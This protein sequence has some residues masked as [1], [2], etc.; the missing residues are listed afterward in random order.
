MRNY[1]YILNEG[2]N[3]YFNK[4]EESQITEIEKIEK[5]PVF[6][7]PNGEYYYVNV[8][9]ENN[10]IYA[11][12]ATNNG[13]IKEFEIDYDVDDTLDGNLSRLYDTIIE[14]RP[15][16]L[17][18]EPIEESL[19][20]LNDYPGAKKIDT[21]KGIAVDT[22][23]VQS[24]EAEEKYGYYQGDIIMDDEPLEVGKSY[25]IDVYEIPEEFWDKPGTGYGIDEDNPYYMVINHKIEEPLEESKNIFKAKPYGGDKNNF[26]YFYVEPDNSIENII[27]FAK[28]NFDSC[29]DK[30][31]EEIEAKHMFWGTDGIGFEEFYNG[32]T[33]VLFDDINKLP[34][35]IKQDALR[36]C[37]GYKKSLVKEALEKFIITKIG[38]NKYALAQGNP[39]VIN[40]R[41]TIE[42]SSSEEAKEI[43]KKYGYSEDELII[44]SCEKDYLKESIDRKTLINAV[45]DAYG[46]TTKEAL[47]WLKKASEDAKAEI[48]KGFKSN[49]NKALLND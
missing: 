3:S 10:T 15:E 43:L 36:H 34:E 35:T 49:A 13:I 42:A 17:N 2:F 32:D 19:E 48:V 4:L 11:G 47:D 18:E 5:E 38:D 45:K 22:D 8:D 46:F 33:F 6:E 44:E 20:V 14:E 27:A 37:K 12:S 26:Y 24:T 40:A 41:K 7:F 31:P 28:E 21:I 16:L 29:K 25:L 1:T 9:K 39:P 23:R 30:S